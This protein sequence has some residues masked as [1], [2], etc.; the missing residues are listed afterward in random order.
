MSP[1]GVHNSLMLLY[2]VV[3][4]ITG[5]LALAAVGLIAAILGVH[6]ILLAIGTPIA[7]LA[8][9][10]WA[11]TL[12]EKHKDKLRVEH[13]QNSS[14]NCGKAMSENAKGSRLTRTVNHGNGCH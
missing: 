10:G 14:L 1:A 11:S 4:V 13:Q 9:A 8:A 5:L 12:K 2:R 3:S 7:M 6:V